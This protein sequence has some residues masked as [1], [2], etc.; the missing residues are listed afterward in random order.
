G[1]Q[2]EQ[3]AG[4]I[5]G[6][7]KDRDLRRGGVQDQDGE[8]RQRRPGDQRPEGRDGLRTPEP[9]EITI[10]PKASRAHRADSIRFNRSWSVG[11]EEPDR[12]IVDRPKTNLLVEVFPSLGRDQVE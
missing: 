3:K 10:P 7:P 8:E 11:A 6:G 9:D 1:E 5:I 12:A 4:D 2:P